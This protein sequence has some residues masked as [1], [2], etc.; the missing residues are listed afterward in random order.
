MATTA[1][2]DSGNTTGKNIFVFA[3]QKQLSKLLLL[4]FSF[5]HCIKT[6]FYGTTSPPEGRKT[7]L[8]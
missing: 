6:K 5:P 1:Q 2:T 3:E 8:Q 7:K 4:I